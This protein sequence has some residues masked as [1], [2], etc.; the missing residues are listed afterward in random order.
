MKYFAPMLLAFSVVSS[1]A[2]ETAEISS[3][4]IEGDRLSAIVK[5]M[6]SDEFAG[7]APGG[8]GE[9]KTVAYLIEQFK[10]LGLEPG[11]GSGSWT[12]PVP[13]WQTQVKNPVFTSVTGKEELRLSQGDD[14]ALS[15]LQPKATVQIDS[16]SVVFVGFG[17]SAPERDWDDYGD[18]ELAGKVAMSGTSA[19]AASRGAEIQRFASI[20]R[21]ASDA[22][23][24]LLWGVD[25]EILY[26]LDWRLAVEH[27]D[28]LVT[29]SRD[30]D[31]TPAPP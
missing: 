28:R 25:L 2:T 10:Q 9:A 29:L 5:V 16:A 13:L 6:A 4:G 3:P 21:V 15:T 23:L 24:G 17:A 20:A 18:V 22:G 7:R 30:G 8:P 31:R 19:A 11:A 27:R 12:Q 14:V 1:N 26:R